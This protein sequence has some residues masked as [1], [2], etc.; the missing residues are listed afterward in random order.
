MTLVGR[1]AVLVCV[2][3]VLAALTAAIHPRAPRLRAT[4]PAIT[5]DSV[6]A[7]VLWIDARPAAKFADGCIPGAVNVSEDAW[8]DGVERLLTVGL[9][10]RQ[11]VVYCDTHTCPAATEIAARLE[12]ELGI[13]EIRILDGGWHTWSAARR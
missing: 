13:A 4:H 2:A 11:L 5:L 12:R 1:A 7:N 3:C 6:P 8:I 9:D 10:Q